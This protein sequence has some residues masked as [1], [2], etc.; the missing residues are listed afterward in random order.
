M[1]VRFHWHLAL[2]QTRKATQQNSPDTFCLSQAAAFTIKGPH[3]PQEEKCDFYV[4]QSITIAIHCTGV[5]MHLCMNGK[6][7]DS[8]A[9][10]QIGLI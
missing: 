2:D 7:V 3:P 9:S 4:F 8:A 10:M 1:C 6:Q 5:C